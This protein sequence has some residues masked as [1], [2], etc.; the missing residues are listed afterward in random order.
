VKAIIDAR[1]I[2]SVTHLR[3]LKPF[4]EPSVSFKLESDLT[5]NLTLCH[6]NL[7]HNIEHKKT[8]HHSSTVST[9][10]L[11]IHT[12]LSHQI[13]NIKL[14]DTIKKLQYEKSVLIKWVN[15]LY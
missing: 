9:V 12:L 1:K 5:K 6:N 8:S 7:C 10:V 13:E 4:S 14:L 15:F 3:K 2:C 11:P